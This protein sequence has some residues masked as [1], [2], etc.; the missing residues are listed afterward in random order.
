MS[1]LLFRFNLFYIYKKQKAAT[2]KK[3]QKL[4]LNKKK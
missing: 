1:E 2:M 4:E 3:A